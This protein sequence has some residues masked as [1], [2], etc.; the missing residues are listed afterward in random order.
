MTD[1]GAVVL[2]FDGVI[3][4]SEPLHLRAFQEVLEE[5]GLRLS[6][7]DYYTHFLGFNDEDAVA[8]IAAAAGRSFSDAEVAAL[9][10]EKAA[11]MTTLLASPEVLFPGAEAAVR[12]LARELPLAIASGARRDEIERVLAARNLTGCFAA[13]VASG[14]TPRSKPAPDPYVRALELLRARGLLPAGP[15]AARRSVAV[16]DSRWGIESARGAGLRCIAVTTSYPP[17]ALAGADVVVEDLARVSL[18]LLRDV[19]AR[20]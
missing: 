9:V 2:D 19:V 15:D 12:A 4:D 13:I 20:A 3:A 6:A 14:E 17:A 5:R 18:E 10:A 8:A 7:E 11:R 1:V 16:E